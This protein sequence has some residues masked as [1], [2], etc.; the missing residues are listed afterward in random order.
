MEHTKW[1]PNNSGP[2]VARDR[3]YTKYPVRLRNILRCTGGGVESFA[4]AIN[5]LRGLAAVSAGYAIMTLCSTGTHVPVS[6]AQIR[7][8]NDFTI[9]AWVLR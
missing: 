8:I 1:K 4:G 5:H 9:S 7:A 6:V 2:R 3:M